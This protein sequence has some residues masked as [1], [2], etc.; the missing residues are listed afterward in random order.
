MAFW[1]NYMLSVATSFS[2]QFCFFV[3]DAPPFIF[4]LS[5]FNKT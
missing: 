1:T 2:V 5:T 3:F 4:I